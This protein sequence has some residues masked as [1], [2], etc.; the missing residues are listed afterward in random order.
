MAVKPSLQLRNTQQLTMTPQLQQAIRLLQLST[1]ELQQ[2]I[3]TAVES[4]PLLEMD[5]A[6]D[7]ETDT[8]AAS[9]WESSAESGG[10]REASSSEVESPAESSAA[11]AEALPDDLPVDAAWDDIYQHGG[12]YDGEAADD[13]GQT[14][15][16]ARR[17]A[18]DRLRERLAW[19]LN[20]AHLTPSDRRI[21]EAIIDALDDRGYLVTT[22]EDL[23]E[24]LDGPDI[25]MEDMEAVLSWVQRLEPVAVGARNLDECLRVQ[26]E[27]QADD[28]SAAR[29][30]ARRLL[31]EG[32]QSLA[33]W[34]AEA[35]AK[36]HGVDHGAVLAALNLIR[37]LKPQ[38]NL[39]LE[40]AAGEYVTPDVVVHRVH[41]RWRV[42]LNPEA[43]PRLRINGFYADMLNQRLSSS[44]EQY[45][46]GRLQEARWLIKSLQSRN[47]TLLK[48][49]RTIVEQQVGFLEY[50]EEA[51]KPLVLRDIA[52]LID[53]HESTISRV[54]NHKYM[55]TPRGLFELKYFFSSQLNTER[56][57][58]CS[59][60]AIRAM[61]KKMVA[62]ENPHKPL[63]DSRIAQLLSERGIR[64]ARRT[65]AKYREALLIPSSTER[66]RLF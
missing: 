22:L 9:E 2:E 31:A 48:V 18:P 35:I 56:G 19:Q 25:E 12:G 33:D 44:D 57:D 55:Q 5:A 46:R 3:T 60:T 45:F 47:E 42:E 8:E 17:S 1:V 62:D 40:E 61:I 11:T 49:A 23:R 4:N 15:W 66:K 51:M 6:A 30:L 37:G 36:R 14:P 43:L 27:Q 39:E 38:P 26:L 24:G 63:S 41:D 29:A 21:A 7:A 10:E 58:G 34:N 64:V 59:S 13:D 65:V 28:G 52:D 20:L 54:T 50:G 32:L 53:M 16:E